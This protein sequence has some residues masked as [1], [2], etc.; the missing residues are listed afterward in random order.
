MA[1][2]RGS[3][4]CSSRE[5]GEWHGRALG[6]AS[7]GAPQKQL[8]DGALAVPGCYNQVSPGR[9]SKVADGVSYRRQTVILTAYDVHL[10]HDKKICTRSALK[11]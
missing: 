4:G 5:D 8:R 1:A 9:L 2:Q 7:S 3:V 10:H 6:K 11:C